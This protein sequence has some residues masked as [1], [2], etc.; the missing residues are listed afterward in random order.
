MTAL[1]WASFLRQLGA[2]VSLATDWHGQAADVL[3]TVHAVKSADALLRAT[4]ERPDLRVVTL[5]SGTDIYPEFAPEET[6]RR[7]LDRADA[8]IALQRHALELLPPPLRQKAR[9]VV[10]SATA[11]PAPRSRRFTAVVLAHLRAI[12]QPLLAIEAVDRLPPDVD[13]RLLLAGARLDDDYS[14]AIA[15]ALARSPRAE[16]LGE[17]NRRA[18]RRLLAGSTVCIVPSRAEGGAN[19]VSEAI[20]AG[21]PVL[22]TAIPGNL[23]LLGDDWPATFAVGDAQALANLLARCADDSRFLDRLGRRIRSLQPL[24]APAAECAAWRRLLRDLVAG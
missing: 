12:K 19:V 8:L 15:T 4:D 16:W 2:R 9:V 1:R 10:Q 6:T 3:V 21:T 11:V 18:S 20:A 13:V 24:V 23:G 22:C 17:L 14:A 5:L 7:A